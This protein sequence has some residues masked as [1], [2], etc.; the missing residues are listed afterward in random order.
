M[1]RSTKVIDDEIDTIICSFHPMESLVS[2]TTIP[3]SQ[4]TP[5]K[6]GQAGKHV[7]IPVTNPANQSSRCREGEQDKEN[8]LKAP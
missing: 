6:S 2:T 1:P 7:P 4:A 3:A 8:L 5:P